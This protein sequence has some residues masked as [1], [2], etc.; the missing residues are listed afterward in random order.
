MSITKEEFER[1]SANE[2]GLKDKSFRKKILNFFKDNKEKAFNVKE[3]S[4]NFEKKYTN[5]FN[6]LNFLSKKGLIEKKGSYYIFKEGC[7]EK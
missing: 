7:N 5:V 4:I 1:K 3:I 6:V 2:L